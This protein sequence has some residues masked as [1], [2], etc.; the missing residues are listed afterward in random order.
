MYISGFLP[1]VNV[2]ETLAAVRRHQCRGRQSIRRR[3][4]V[5]VTDIRGSRRGQ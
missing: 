2:A 1:D 4:H 5:N 3:C